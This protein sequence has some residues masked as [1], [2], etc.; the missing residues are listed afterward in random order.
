M[1]PD[2]TIVLPVHNGMPYLLE[3]LQS[4]LQQTAS[5]KPALRSG[6]CDRHLVGGTCK[7]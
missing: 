2:V 4:I 3:A 7:A 5:L 6:W 1:R